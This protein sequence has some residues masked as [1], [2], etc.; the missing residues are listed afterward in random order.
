M[1]KL[2]NLI[3]YVRFLTKSIYGPNYKM[4]SSLLSKN[5][6]VSSKSIDLSVNICSSV[7]LYTYKNSKRL[8]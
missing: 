6:Q 4:S 8:V 7:V 5:I 1:S 2:I 3:T